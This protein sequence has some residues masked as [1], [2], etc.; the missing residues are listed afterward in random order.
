MIYYIEI[1]TCNQCNRACHWC[2]YGN[3]VEFRN[4]KIEYLDTIYI[5]KVVEEL[6]EHHFTGS[7][8][9]H[10]MN[11]PLLD[12]R[13]KEGT[14]IQL[15]KNIM[16]DKVKLNIVTNGDLLTEEILCKMIKSGL[17]AICIS[18]YDNTIFDKA[19]M[20]Y[21]KYHK[22]I[23]FTI[24]DYR[25]N[26]KFNNRAG[27]VPMNGVYKQTYSWCLL[28]ACT[29]IIGWNGEVRLCCNDAT[30]KLRLGNIKEQK[31][32]DILNSKKMKEYRRIITKERN[33][34]S[35]CDQCNYPG[36]QLPMQTNDNG[37]T[38]FLDM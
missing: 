3:N 26:R 7:I 5:K 29:S 13:I 14:L 16:G 2:V 11:E 36:I 32:F 21:E 38:T 1:E 10:S 15:C 9:L 18:C 22:Q 6:K 30:G 12:D 27:N 31:L 4:R 35:P 8:S 19:R 33:E 24:Y 23:N 37:I 34:I 20:L 17:D 28:P 25:E